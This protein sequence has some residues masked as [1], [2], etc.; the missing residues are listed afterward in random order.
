[1]TEPV[2]I[3][4]G[5]LLALMVGAQM[6]APPLVAL[7]SLFVIAAL[8]HSSLIHQP[9][10][11]SVIV[12]FVIL[13]LLM[14]PTDLGPHMRRRPFT[15]ISSVLLRWVVLLAILLI[16][17]QVSGIANAYSRTAFEA[18][19]LIT[20]ILLVVITMIGG[21]GRGRGWPSQSH[22]C[23]LQR[24]QSRAGAFARKQPRVAD[25]GGGIL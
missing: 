12:S 24:Q 20:P 2:F 3:K 17:A 11:L 4:R 18:W 5:L 10:A 6:L 13:V 22:L 14:P 19:A 9:S 8:S 16:L 21:N 23:R 7:A 1:L 25:A 15:S